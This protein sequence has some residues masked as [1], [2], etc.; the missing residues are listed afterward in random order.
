MQE[1]LILFAFPNTEISCTFCTCPL[2]AKFL[3]FFIGSGQKFVE[4]NK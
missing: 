3:P 4:L 1:A 2:N